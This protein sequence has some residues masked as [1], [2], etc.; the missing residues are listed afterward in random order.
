MFFG[1]AIWAITLHIQ[2]VG[3]E[4]KLQIQ[5]GGWKSGRLDFG[6]LNCWTICSLA[7]LLIQ[8]D[9]YPTDSCAISPTAFLLINH[10]MK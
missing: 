1:T 7:L 8:M 2:S 6:P 5:D 4:Q 3:G 9:G 10:S